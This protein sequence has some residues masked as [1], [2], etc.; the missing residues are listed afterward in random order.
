METLIGFSICMVIGFIA[1][2]FGLD[3]NHNIVA[4]PHRTE[5]KP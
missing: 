1:W 2:V 5:K 4:S 3:G